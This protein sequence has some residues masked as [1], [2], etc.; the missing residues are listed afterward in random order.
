MTGDLYFKRK[1]DDRK[2]VIYVNLTYFSMLSYQIIENMVN[3]QPV[4]GMPMRYKHKCLPDSDTFT[5]KS[6]FASHMPTTG[7]S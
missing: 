2:W 5:Q 7:S 3:N 4:V 1:S 6:A